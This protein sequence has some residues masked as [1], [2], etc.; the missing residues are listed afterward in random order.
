M[1]LDRNAIVPI[2]CQCVTWEPRGDSGANTGGTELK[3]A[4]ER[5]MGGRGSLSASALAVVALLALVLLL[6]APTANAATEFCPPGS[7]AGECGTGADVNS[8]RGLAVD[9]E[10]GRL[11]VADRGN[12][13]VDVFEEDG[14]FVFAFGWG[15]DTGAQTLQT[16]TTASTCQAG[17][18]G[19]GAGQFKAPVRIAVDN[20]PASPSQH[21][22]YVA[23][24]ANLEPGVQNHRV[25]KFDSTGAFLWM[26]GEEVD[27]TSGGDLCTQAS[28]DTCGLGLDTEAEGGFKSG[29]LPGVG[30]GGVLYVVDSPRTGGIAKQ[31]LQRFEP[32][33]ALIPPQVVLSEIPETQ[34]QISV[35]NAIAVDPAGNAWVAT[36]G[37]GLS[38]Y[39]ATGTL[40][41]GP[42]ETDI[43]TRFL[44]LDAGGNLFALQLE[45]G[46]NGYQVVARYDSG[47]AI[48]RR[49]GY[50]EL[51]S[52]A[53]FAPEGLAVGEA[54]PFLSV[55]DAGIKL[56]VEPPPG[57]IIAPSSVEASPRSVWASIGAEI[58]PEGKTTKYEVEYVDKHSY[59]T[60]GGFAS[61]KTRNGGEVT[62]SATDF[63]IHAI[64]DPIAG[65]K[66]YSDQA[67][68]EGKCLI[69]ETKYRFRL[70]VR[71]G[72]AED[73]AE[74]EFMTL[75]PVEFEALYASEVGTDSATLNA[76]VNP[77]GS[78]AT[79]HF[80]YIDEAGY[81]AGIQAA[82][83]E[84]KSR[85]EAEAEGRGFDHAIEAPDVG[86]GAAPID[87]GAEEVTTRRS[88]TLYPLAPG[89][90][91]RY[92]L[93]AADH[94][95]SVIS[96]A[97]AFTTFEPQGVEPGGC[98]A[99]EGFRA[100]PAGL[101]PDC[102]AYE[103]V[104]P[105]EKGG[106][107][108]RVLESLALEQSADSGERLAFGSVRSFGDAAS[109]PL[110]SQYIAQRMAG[111]EWQTHSINSP[112]GE[113][114]IS[115]GAHA[116]T[117]TEFKFFSDDLCEGWQV[118][119]AEPPLAEGGVEGFSN[120][121]RREDRLCGPEGYEALAPLAKPQ[122]IPG[123]APFE[124]ELQGVSDDG[125]HTVFRSN[126]KIKLAN[127]TLAGPSQVFEAVRGVGLRLVCRLPGGSPGAPLN[128]K[129]TAGTNSSES[130]D[131]RGVSA[132]GAVSTDGER[133]YWT[134]SDFGDGRLYVRIGGAQTEDVS[135]AAE[136][137]AGSDG[138]FF[139]GASSD[140][141]KAVFTTG[142]KLYEFTLAG[143]TTTMLAEGALGVMGMSKDA[144]RIYFASSKALAGSGANSEGDVAAEGKPNLYLH[145]TGEGGG[146]TTFV[147]MLAPGDPTIQGASPLAKEP[148]NRNARV[149]PDGAHAAFPSLAALTGYDNADVDTGEAAKELYVYDAEAGK[150]SCASC[151]PSGARPVSLIAV[152]GRF[153]ARIPPYETQLHPLRAL[154]DD[155]TRLVFESPDR[156][157]PRDS[158]G[159]IDIYQWEAPGAGTCAQSSP[160]FSIQNEGCVSLISSGDSPI[161]SRLVEVT[162][163]GGNVFFATLSS[164]LPQDYGLIDIY[165]ARVDGGLPVP[166]EPPAP[167]EG[168]SCH[169]PSAA[170]VQPTP[171]SSAVRGHKKAPTKKH[172]HKGCPKGKRAVGAKGR[173]HCVPKHKRHRRRT[174][175]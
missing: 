100:G 167:C 152:S 125:T 122:G 17:L 80:Q 33:G 109:A 11:Y 104:S 172:P 16:C 161:D 41:T 6:R 76:E 18:A 164:F 10:T 29:V 59:E 159:A 83:E 96:E 110:T 148:R 175:R 15:V 90:T 95:A 93:L 69:P 46:K 132:T 79:G 28:G 111:Q 81:E 72:D 145:E 48:Q 1:F 151:N 43:E 39:S 78:A 22:I 89:T 58:N 149:S 115:L 92:R 165:D 123:T 139:W 169:N 70:K 23:E 98:P 74:G 140:G 144:S 68:D 25:Q 118:T 35:A 127:G 157:A 84:G 142:G 85:A 94:F 102:R 12:N 113:P 13:R 20:D 82:E 32:S 27:K 153:A 66:P 117:D 54:G 163:D 120:L 21:A 162:P 126:S 51:G 24:E 158:N 64:E 116:R 173:R 114:V 71:N 73:E 44:G 174:G 128:G 131:T 121:Y 146:R 62:L 55:G 75:N 61:P 134:D 87:F 124:M 97:K 40:L 147:A 154:S 150:L 137:E 160:S 155:G 8:Q 37:A 53:P 47:G 65:C 166:P 77:L 9:Y 36:Q 57:P 171:A 60:E 56:L 14:T 99:N 103:L 133:I 170:P 156:L 138:S 67:F 108:I 91:Y 50:D 135:K 86:G 119:V 7:G 3:H 107:D 101:L 42:I 141:G 52:D 130:P 30:P 136:D 31:R 143:K 34:A 45:Q 5:E 88:E 168:D 106:S 105:L 26:V 63:S 129:C 2:S 19:V 49:F 38:E 112:Q 4:E